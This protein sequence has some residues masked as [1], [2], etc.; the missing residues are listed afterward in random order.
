MKSMAFL[1]ESRLRW[2]GLVLFVLANHCVA[3][4]HKAEEAVMGTRVTV[5]VWNEDPVT[6]RQSVQAV[7]DDMHRINRLMSPYLESSEISRI[8]REAAAHPVTCAPEL[9]HLVA[10]SLEVSEMTDGAFDITFA[11]AGHLYNYREGVHPDGQQIETVLPAI[12]YKNVHLDPK[13]FSIRFA[14]D[15]VQIDLGGIAKGHAVDRGIRILAERGIEHAIV[16]AGGDSRVRGEHGGRP[17]SV[18]IR[19]PRDPDG[20]VAVLPLVDTAISTSGD[21]ERFFIEDGVRYHHILD[22]GTG[23]SAD[24]VRSVSV[25]GPDATTTD[26]LSTSVFVM[27]ARKGLALVD[28]LPDIE[29]VIIDKHGKMQFSSGLKRLDRPD[30][31]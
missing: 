7:M 11:S 20:L 9:F 26:A 19:D 13:T 25:I 31:N 12:N 30:K 18:G 15:G 2:F 1:P 4:W 5:E 29:A 17:W 8:N 10:R 24:S 21:Y 22:P 23:R 14:R 3:E 6:A 16:T 27:G 28:S